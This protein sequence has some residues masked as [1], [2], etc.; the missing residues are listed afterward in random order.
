[1]KLILAII[2]D[3][4]ND[5]VSRRL[6]DENYRVTYIASTGGFFRSG[7]STLL[8]GVEPERVQKALDLIRESTTKP[9]SESEKQATIFVL[10]IEEYSQL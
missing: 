8:I 5:K 7:R 9:E 2:K 6:T 10:D 1:M 4:D 3:A